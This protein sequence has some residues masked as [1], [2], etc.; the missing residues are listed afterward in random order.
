MGNNPI[1]IIP[2]RGRAKT[3][4]TWKNA[5]EDTIL[6]INN[7]EIKEYRAAGI[8]NEIWGHDCF[9]SVD[10]RNFILNK[11]GIG[12][13]VLMLDDDIS[14]VGRF[15]VVNGKNKSV[16]MELKDWIKE[17]L[18]LFDVSL[19]NK[20]HFFGVAPTS[21]PLCFNGKKPFS[22][23]VFINGACMGII[24]SGAMFDKFCKVKCDYEFTAQHIVSGLGVFRANYLW[25]INDFDKMPGGRQSYSAGEK[26]RES[27]Y[28]YL[29]A[30]YPNLFRPNPKRKWE[31]ILNNRG[32]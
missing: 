24:S 4:I 3:G 21:N 22:K 17:V 12:K 10:V 9:C 8:K 30:K 31:I 28:R 29:L 6:A 2:T 18:S 32:K 11:A 16:K 1:V 19:K 26:D 23:N 15:I 7:Q 14:S 13:S 27:S 25:Q 5:P 20:A